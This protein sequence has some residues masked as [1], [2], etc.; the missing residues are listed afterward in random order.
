MKTILFQG[1]SITDA[2]RDFSNPAS[3][4]Y[5]YPAMTA[6]KIG[7]DYPGCFRFLNRGVSGNRIVDLYA[8]IRRDIINQKL[9]LAHQTNAGKEGD[10]RWN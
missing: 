7:V 1:D 2:G 5:G 8:R 4:G 6:G 9:A 10:I 3:L